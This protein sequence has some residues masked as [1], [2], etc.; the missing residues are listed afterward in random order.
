MILK[1]QSKLMKKLGIGNKNSGNSTKS[2]KNSEKAY[3]MESLLNESSSD[4]GNN[5][6]EESEEDDSWDESTNH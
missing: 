2:T 4:D 3:D 5:E 6:E 1:T